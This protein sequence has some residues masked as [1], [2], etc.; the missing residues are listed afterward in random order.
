MFVSWQSHGSVNNA[1]T[2][3]SLQRLTV[4]DGLSQ[5]T[6]N[7]VFQDNEGLLWFGTQSGLNVYDGYRFRVLPGPNEK[8]RTSSFF[9]IIQDKQSI[10]W[11]L[12]SQG[13]I[14]F[15]KLKDKYHVALEHNDYYFTDLVEGDD[16]SLWVSS[17]KTIMKYDIVKKSAKVIANF[18]SALGEGETINSIHRFK[19][20][21]YVATKIGVFVLNTKSEQW[22][23]L[24]S[25]NDKALVKNAKYDRV[26][27]LYVTDE[28]NLYLGAFKGLFKLDVSAIESYLA[29]D[30]ALG[31]YSLI[32]AETS[33]WTFY[34]TEKSLYVGSQLGLSRMDFS[35]EKIQ[36]ELAFND[37]YDDINN[38]IIT[39]I[40][41]DKRGAF[42]FG[43]SVSGIYKWDTKLNLINRLRYQKSNP[44]RL[45]DNVIWAVTKS[46]TNNEHLW[47]STENGINQFNV[48]TNEVKRFL[49]N[50]KNKSIYN[51]SYIT[52]LFEDDFERLWL[53]T[54]KG[55][56][57]FDIKTKQL[58]DL[59]FS[60]A[61]NQALSKEHYVIFLDDYGFLWTISNDGF[62]R[63]NIEIGVVDELVELEKIASDISIYN[64]LGFLPNSTEMLI[65]TNQ[66]LISFNVETREAKLLYKHKGVVENDGSYFESWLI[67]KNNILWLTLPTQ[68]LIGLDAITYQLHCFYHSDNVGID[69]NTYGLLEDIDGDIWFSSHNGLYHL[70]N[71][72]QHIRNFNV[73]DGL[74]TRE[75]NANSFEKVSNKLFVYGSING[76]NIFNPSELKQK[77]RDQPLTVVATNIEV[78]S[79]KIKLPFILNQ[80]EKVKLNYDDVSIRF[81]FSTL[82]YQNENLLF[83]FELSGE[84]KVLY[85]DTKDNFITFP[86]LPSGEHVLSVKVKSPSTGEYSPV[87]KLNISVSYAPWAS[88]TAYLIY[89]IL[90][91]LTVFIWLYRRKQHT[92]QLIDAHEEVKYREQRLSLALRGSNSE[93]WDWF[94]KDNLIFSPR[95]EKELGYKNL[96]TS[97]RF[98]KHIELIHEGDL[99]AFVYQ[100]NTFLDN[101]DLNDNFSCTYRLRNSEGE[102]LWYK[103]L[104]KIVDTDKN[105]KPTRITGSYTNITQSRA[106]AER[107]QYYGDAFKKTQDWVLIITNDFTRVTVNE[108]LR[109]VFGWQKNEFPFEGNILGLNEEKVKFYRS[110]LFSFKEGDHWRGEEIISTQD[111][112]EYH[113]LVNI[114]VSRNATTNALHYVCIFTDITAQKSAEKELRY[115]AN[116]D[117]L[118][119]FTKPHFI[120]RTH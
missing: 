111:T 42:W 4:E 108:S 62:R 14:S 63:I 106:D 35:N 25:I 26:Y 114:N 120:I 95:A 99:E 55:I 53:L 116:Y 78:L 27:N 67:D 23:K 90:F 91:I 86:S 92:Q 101:A 115:L 36:H 80:Q 33:S 2:N 31:P 20:F 118:T 44:N 98:A 103:D 70:N 21:I 41:I 1:E 68:G 104:G 37:V 75:F 13:L 10:L 34:A 30:K 43:S 81:D 45:S 110:L 84:D 69:R 15:D 66:D 94:A 6:V 96:M 46:K 73:A 24:P 107:A 50:K 97:H 56:K 18:S 88:P 105:G 57:L 7:K 102:W 28:Q 39:S 74:S 71:D 87:T 3:V 109:K 100:W 47:I 72:N 19:H 40:A 89:S 32:D 83:S 112:D 117:H 64:V 113:V 22:K 12:S 17:N 93:V 76:L 52:H 58:V 5:G 38:N 11:F 79:R 8:F 49:V 119:D 54:A 51:E 29:D 9:K 16:R 48:S 61:I 82:T 65:S 60:Q 85:P 77:N 59:P